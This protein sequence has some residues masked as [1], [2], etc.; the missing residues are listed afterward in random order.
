M[1]SAPRIVD[2][3]GAEITEDSKPGEVLVKGPSLMTRYL[4]NHEATAAAFENG[5]LRT[6]D[7]GYCDT[8]KWY[9]IDRAKV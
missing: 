2:E 8:G 6:G 5:W 4:G 3:D 7:I 1:R 9:I